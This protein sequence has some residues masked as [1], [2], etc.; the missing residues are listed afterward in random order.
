SGRDRRRT[1][2]PPA[3]QPRAGPRPFPLCG[4][5]VLPCHRLDATAV[6]TGDGDARQPNAEAERLLRLSL[7]VV[8]PM[9]PAETRRPRNRS[10]LHPLCE[11][12]K[13]PPDGI[14]TAKPSLCL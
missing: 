7:P 5:S 12:Q 13:E 6:S 2:T 1:P 10:F 4:L 9:F 11:H 14:R 3:A 8:P